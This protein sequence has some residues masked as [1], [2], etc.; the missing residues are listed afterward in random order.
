MLVHL[1]DP[2]AVRSHHWGG[3]LR[4]EQNFPVREI[5]DELILFGE[6]AMAEEYMDRLEWIPL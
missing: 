5:A 2:W 6:A 3:S 4:H 1:P